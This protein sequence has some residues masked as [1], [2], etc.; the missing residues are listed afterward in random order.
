MALT[1][2]TLILLSLY[3]IRPAQADGVTT[4]TKASALNTSVMNCLD[5]LVYQPL[6]VASNTL[7][8]TCPQGTAGLQDQ[9]QCAGNV[10]KPLSSLTSTDL[11]GYCAQATLTPYQACDY[12]NGNEGYRL[13]SSVFG[14]T[15]QAPV[16]PTMTG[17]A[18]ISWSAPATNTDGS[19][20][21]IT[22]YRIEYGQ[23]DFSQ[24]VTTTAT[25]YT[26]Q[27]LAA[28]TW[29]FRIVAI[30]ASGQSAPSN[31][32][33]VTIAGSQ[34]CAAAPATATQTVAC[35]SGTTGT[36]T[37]THGWTSASYPTCWT[38]NAWTPTSPPTGS[39]QAVTQ[40]WL[41]SGTGTRP[42]YEAVLPLSG[43]GL[44]LGNQDGTISAG[45]ACGTEQFKQGSTSYRSVANTDTS[46]RSPTYAN[47]SHV[48]A[49]VLQ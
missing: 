16:N 45:K 25:T 26:F 17:P 8:L 33:T 39:C 38:A 5:A 4:C 49:C 7:V 43:S 28:G 46:L 12:P 18:Q 22:S 10:W 2:L 34:T 9:A 31:P 11:V 36:W 3:L 14:S 29:Q 40:T 1:A 24:S 23:T 35:P 42:V 48:A 21:V 37:Q 13:Y 32:V 27:S 6:P 15:P 41:V 44:V 30:S 47:R 20:V 19:A